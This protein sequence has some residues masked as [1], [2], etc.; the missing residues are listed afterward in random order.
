MFK[1]KFSLSI[2]LMGTI[3]NAESMQLNNLIDNAK[4]LGIGVALWQSS[5][6]IHELGHALTAK[7]LNNTPI[8]ITLGKEDS[9]KK[10]FY[11]NGWLTIQSPFFLSGFTT[12]PNDPNKRWK[13]ITKLSAGPIAGAAF[14][15]GALYHF[16][17]E[18]N[19][20]WTISPALIIGVSIAN[21]LPGKNS[22]SDGEK[23][24]HQF[25]PTNHKY[26]LG[27]IKNFIGQCIIGYTIGALCSKKH[28]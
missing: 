3:S 24:A 10:P 8:N 13:N 4:A 16:R 15:L 5:I 23:I 28:F 6:L 12:S 17:N 9:N 7:A 1:K 2:A 26:C 22:Q 14:G 18:H 25:S 27:P 20:L 21:L 19:I 11:E